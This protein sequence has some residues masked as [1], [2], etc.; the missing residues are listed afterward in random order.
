M[1]E[2][3]NPGGWFHTGASQMRQKRPT[4][5]IHPV[6]LAN[7]DIRYYYNQP[8]LE[9]AEPWSLRPEIPSHE[10]IL[11]T[12]TDDTVIDLVPNQIKGPWGS[13]ETY[14]QAHYDLLREDSVAPLRDAVAYVR[15]N[16]TMTDSKSVS[17]YDKVHIVGLTFAQQGL[18]F[19]VQ[20]S[21]QRSRKRIIWEYTKRLISG[22]IVA[23]SP[24][25]DAFQA[26]CVIAI[27]AARPLEQVQLQPPQIDI[28]FAQPEDVDFDP[29]KEW[30]MVEARTGYYEA[31]RH[32]MTALQKM[33]RETFPLAENICFLQP[34]IEPP[35]YVQQNPIVKLQ[36][37]IDE[38]Q[39]EG[40][41]DV[42]NGW[43]GAPTGD[44]DDT[45]WE[46][47]R[48]I[49]TKRLAI[50][51]GPPGTGKTFVSVVAL[52]VLI[53]NMK[54]DDP[55][56]I[57]SSQTN[58]ALDQLLVHISRFEQNYI[59][60]G[61]RSSDL[62]VKKHTLFNVKKTQPTVSLH[63]SI[64]GSARGKQRSLQQGILRL[65]KPFD[66]EYIEAPLPSSLFFEYG[67]LTQSQFDSLTKGAK[68]WIRPS[69]REDAD[70]ISAWLGDQLVRFKVKYA[71][72]NFGFAEDEV[73]LEYE[74]L[75]E[76]DAEHGVDE[77]DYDILR[78][79]YLHI[80]EGFRGLRRPDKG[81]IDYRKYSDMWRIPVKERGAVYGVL[82]MLA[83]EK[84][85]SHL[86]PLV[87]EYT[88][89]SKD[90][91]IGKWERDS[92]FLQTAKVIGV[93]ATGLSKYRG[94]I[95]SLK[96]KIVLIEEAAEVI[97]APIAVSCLES[98]QHMILVGDH[99]QL[100]GHCS[101]EELGGEPFFLAVSMFER[102]VNNGLE[103]VTL[104]K[105]RRMAPEIRRLLDPI[106]GK[107]Q[108]HESVHQRPDIPGMGSVR[109]YFFTH[110]WPE[111]SD[112]LSSKVNEMEAEMIVGFYVHL[113][114]SG[115]PV[116]D[117]TILTFYNGQ[118]KKLLKMLRS[119]SY[120][121]GDTIPCTEWL[122]HLWERQ[123]VDL[124]ESLMARGSW[125]HGGRF[126]STAGASNA[127][128]MQ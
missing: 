28:Y 40:K 99:Q 2:H 75:K 4:M 126:I 37:A 65:L 84:V 6:A 112:S 55:P 127:G 93:T 81:A 122:L 124:C 48:Q 41:V 45:Q 3:L 56:I 117:I 87:A 5:K 78:G 86:R 71:A 72:D 39:R 54:P 21:T 46:A 58:H 83:K 35:A 9:E 108:D 67:L 18:G 111:S 51:Q 27:V 15:A 104:R 12:E 34:N 64:L 66:L 43:P 128:Y 8:S 23:L 47:L 94:L 123:N 61:S 106:Y 110:D 77:D 105:Q 53:S 49:L 95:A 10:E 69:D 31:S 85:L 76:L 125:Y 30:I 50:V 74:Q 92:I 68:D 116:Q 17:I 11:G 91:Q 107:L 80:G 14:L 38:T 32:T 63:G 22:T 119:N 13:R 97:E 114:L 26:E 52:K 29:H 98:V 7:K 118:R 89:N 101:V 109:S 90:I 62:D 88:R 25:D 115:V 70:P 57:V 73:D 120:L 60:L 42:L 103:Y 36:S 1:S 33:R 44:L 82:C 59:R 121:Q 24:A 96:P 19:R 100:K 20:F 16:P 113:V 79:D 102:L